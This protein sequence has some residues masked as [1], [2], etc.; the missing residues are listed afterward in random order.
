MSL[1]TIS[2]RSSRRGF[3]LIELVIVVALI[4]IVAVYA[5]PSFGRL[6]ESNRVSSTANGIMGML[7]YTR[8][9]A[10][11][12][13]RTVNVRPVDGASW[14]SGLLVWLDL[15]GDNTFDANEE[16][17]RFADMNTGLTIAGSATSIGFRG[18]GFLTPASEANFQLSV[19]STNTTTSFVC[20]G[21]AGRIRTAGSACN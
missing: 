4:S 2:S 20:T 7:R 15:D 16:L 9:E 10:V 12:V 19:A 17:R 5:V 21:L 3:T 11:K 8:S 18:N 1:E 14:S 6:I 13:G